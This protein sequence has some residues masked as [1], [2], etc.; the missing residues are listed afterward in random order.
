MRF[1]LIA[2]LA[3]GLSACGWLPNHHLDYRDASSIKPMQVPSD[4]VFIGEQALFP[5]AEGQPQPEYESA[6]KDTIPT[7]PQLVVLGEEA[8][9]EPVPEANADDPTNTR[10]V[11]ARDGNGYPI[12]MMHTSFSWAWEYVGQALSATD[13]KID[14]RDRESGTYY[15]RTPKKYEI[16]GREAQIKLSHTVNGIQIAVLNRKGSALLDK[17][18]GQQIIQRLYDQL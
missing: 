5:V 9:S 4:M 2:T 10:V 13:L 6:K 3:A 17:A 11:M 12:I 14:D 7:P 1:F 18:P 8:E 16:D 15:V